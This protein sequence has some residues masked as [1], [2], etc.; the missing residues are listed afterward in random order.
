MRGDGKG[1]KRHE[2]RGKEKKIDEKPSKVIFRGKGGMGRDDE[3]GK[4]KRRE[5]TAEKGKEKK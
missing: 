4:G 1:K 5:E 3:K 2:G